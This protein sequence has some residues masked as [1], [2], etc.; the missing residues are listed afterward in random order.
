MNTFLIART[1]ARHVVA[2]FAEH[3][4]RGFYA[5]RIMVDGELWNCRQSDNVMKDAVDIFTEAFT[6]LGSQRQGGAAVALGQ[7]A[8]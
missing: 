5:M 3:G 6:A 1:L 2:I 8:L 7:N 4:V